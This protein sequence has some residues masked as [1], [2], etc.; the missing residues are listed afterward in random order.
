MPQLLNVFLSRGRSFGHIRKLSPIC[1][2]ADPKDT[3][4]TDQNFLNCMQFSGKVDKN[5]MSVPPPTEILVPPLV[6]ILS[7][8]LVP[9]S[10]GSS[11]F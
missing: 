1:P 6:A 7:Y 8:P 5:Y 9:S 2:V 4:P 10:S 3:P 11:L